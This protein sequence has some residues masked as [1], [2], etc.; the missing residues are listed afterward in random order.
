MTTCTFAISVDRVGGVAFGGSIILYTTTTIAAIVVS[1][2]PGTEVGRGCISYTLFTFFTVMYLVCSIL[3]CIR[4]ASAGGTTGITGTTLYVVTTTN[5]VFGSLFV[6]SCG[7]TDFS[8]A[9]LAVKR[10]GEFSNSGSC[11][12]VTR[13]RGARS[14][15]RQCNNDNVR[16]RRVGGSVL[17]NTCSSINCLDLASPDAGGFRGRVNLICGGFS[18]LSSDRTSPCVCTLRGIGCCIS[19][20]SRGGRD[21]VNSRD[22]TALGGVDDRHAC[23][24]RICRGGSCV[25][26]NFACRG[27]VSRDRCSSLDPIRGERTLLRTTIL[28][29]ASRCIGS[30]LSS[31]DARICGPRC[32]AILP[33][34]NYVVG[35]GAVCSRGDNARVRLGAS[36]RRNCRACVRF[37]GLDCASLDKVR[38]GGVVSPSTCGGLA[39]CRHHGVSC[40]RG[41][42]RPDACTSTVISSSSDTEAPFSVSAPGRSCCDNVGSFAIGLKSGPVGSVALHINSNTC[43]C[44]SVRVVYV[45]GASCGT[46]LGTLTRRRLRS[47]GVT[48]GRVSNDVGLRDSGILFLSVPCGRG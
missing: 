43:T 15:I 1:L 8:A 48:M 5:I 21:T 12:T 14:T 37:G 25:P 2:I 11:G 18:V 23:G 6:C 32:G 45:P 36:I 22:L 42:F 17:D 31:V 46:G 24:S 29:S 27:I 34:G 39:A 47:L 7:R 20:N 33:R 26:F 41:G 4:G 44:S 9:F 3:P 35:S 19:N 28:G 40:G 16:L 30:S 10:T 13:L 38:L